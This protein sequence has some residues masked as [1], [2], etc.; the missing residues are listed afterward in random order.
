MKRKTMRRATLAAFS[1]AAMAGAA[2]AGIVDSP[3]PPGTVV[4]FSVPG[5]IAN[6]N[7]QTYFSCTNASTASFVFGVQVFDENG[8]L[9]SAD[10]CGTNLPVGATRIIGTSGAN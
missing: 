8:N 10:G 4:V 7:L 6:N 3:V 5:V 1:V 2:H 9:V